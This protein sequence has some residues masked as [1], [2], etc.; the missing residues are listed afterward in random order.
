M[1]WL[2]NISDAGICSS[3]D[4]SPYQ[5]VFRF[6]FKSGISSSSCTQHI[7]ICM[8]TMGM[9]EMMRMMMMRISMMGMKMNFED[10][11]QAEKVKEDDDDDWSKGIE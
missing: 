3:V 11:N 4:V 10:D 5:Q 1:V 8:I 2:G 9:P 7:A 6:A